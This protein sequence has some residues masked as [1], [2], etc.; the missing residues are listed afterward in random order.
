VATLVL[1]YRHQHSLPGALSWSW[2]CHFS[3]SLSLFSFGFSF[4]QLSLSVL[5]WRS[6]RRVTWL[7]IERVR[8]FYSILSNYL[9]S[10]GCFRFPDGIRRSKSSTARLLDGFFWSEPMIISAIKDSTAPRLTA[11]DQ[12]RTNLDHEIQNQRFRSISRYLAHFSAVVED[13]N[14]Y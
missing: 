9:D 1:F 11:I 5:N 12:I 10:V 7:E 2:I 6:W 3:L 13:P 8:R 4:R 14:P